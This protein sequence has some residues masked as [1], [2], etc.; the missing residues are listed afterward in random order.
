MEA[1]YITLSK[2]FPNLKTLELLN[3]DCNLTER[4]NYRA[5]DIKEFLRFLQIPDFTYA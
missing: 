1:N 2:K 3:D 5:D 4:T